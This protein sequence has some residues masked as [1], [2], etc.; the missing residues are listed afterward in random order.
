MSP[1]G[2][3]SFFMVDWNWGSTSVRVDN[4]ISSHGN[5]GAVSAL[6]ARTGD[7]CS[8]CFLLLVSILKF[9]FSP[10][11]HISLQAEC[12][13]S[14][15]FL[16]AFTFWWLVIV[17]THPFTPGIACCFIGVITQKVCATLLS[18]QVVC[19]Y[20]S[21]IRNYFLLMNFGCSYKLWKILCVL[22]R[23]MKMVHKWKL[24]ILIIA[25]I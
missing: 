22:S 4:S 19:V 10:C 7:S 1:I 14:T 15:C 25:P 20:V 13:L 24:M 11:E 5:G 9:I 2:T 16:L 3:E 17:F 8:S 21:F 6:M 18:A 23:K 12:A